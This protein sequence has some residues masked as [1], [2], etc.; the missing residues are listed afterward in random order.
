MAKR[1]GLVGK[2]VSYSFSKRYFT[3]KFRQLLLEDHFYD[4]Y[5]ILSIENFTEI[6]KIPNLAGLNITIPYKT[7]VLSFLDSLSEEAKIIGA[8][9]TVK[10]SENRLKGYNTDVFGFEKTLMLHR[11]KSHDSALILGDGGA[12]RAVKYVLRKHGI[13]FL[14]VK[15]NSD[16]DFNS[17][18]YKEIKEN[19]II[20]QTT[21]VGTFPNVQESV[22]FPFE[23]CTEN[24]LVIDLVYNPSSTC[25][26]KNAGKYGAR[27]VNGYYMLEQQ[28]EKSWEIWNDEKK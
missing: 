25:F 5:D 13:P 20:I 1:F 17:L 19:K 14:V 27:C 21:P 6:I 8:V 9:N 23:G 10:F 24:H 11:K 28:A 16:I 26:M 15:R 18:T 22:P 7:E 2:N 4:T 12:A 3:E